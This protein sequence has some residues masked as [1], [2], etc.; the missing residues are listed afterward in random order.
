MDLACSCNNFIPSCYLDFRLLIYTFVLF[1]YRKLGYCHIP[2]PSG[3][4]IWSSMNSSLW[5]RIP[6]FTPLLYVLMEFPFVGSKSGHSSDLCWLAGRYGITYLKQRDL[7]NGLVYRTW[8][9][10]SRIILHLHLHKEQERHPPA[11]QVRD[12]SPGV[13]AWL[14]LWP[15]IGYCQRRHICYTNR[16]SRHGKIQHIKEW[17]KTEQARPKPN[18]DL[19]LRGDACGRLSS[20]PTGRCTTEGWMLY[21]TR[22]QLLSCV[23]I[24]AYYML[25]FLNSFSTAPPKQKTRKPRSL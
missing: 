25:G 8:L 13:L 17:A 24:S 11:E 16:R 9:I 14:Q 18:V 15:L 1:F 12:S 5:F 2:P 23:L 3:S 4:R 20:F 7:C 10:N 22:V 21:Q 6:P 19:N